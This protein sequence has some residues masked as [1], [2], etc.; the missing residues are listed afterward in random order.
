MLIIVSDIS[1]R[2]F[3]PINI[4]RTD[5]GL[6]INI[7]YRRCYSIMIKI[8]ILQIAVVEGARARSRRY[9]RG[10]TFL[11]SN[12]FCPGKKFHFF[13]PSGI[14][15]LKSNALLISIRRKARISACESAFNDKCAVSD[16]NCS[17][18]YAF[19]DAAEN[20]FAYRAIYFTHH[21]ERRET[22]TRGGG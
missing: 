11:I 20:A 2:L 3:A 8:C 22:K 4:Q 21:G 9:R 6:H 19:I 16:S 5:Q 1:G 12:K 10:M 17:S 13:P 14:F 18:V 7:I 15:H